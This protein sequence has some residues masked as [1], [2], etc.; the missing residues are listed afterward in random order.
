MSSRIWATAH[1]LVFDGQPWNCHGASLCHLYQGS[2]LVKVDLSAILD[3]FDS[4]KFM[5]C[6]QMSFSPSCVLPASLLFH[7]Q[8]KC[9]HQDIFF[10][11]TTQPILT[12]TKGTT[13]IV[14]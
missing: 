10:L 4:T 6:P 11:S 14:L 5:F 9:V 2:G 13:I 3:P 7:D 8:F 1:F 12:N